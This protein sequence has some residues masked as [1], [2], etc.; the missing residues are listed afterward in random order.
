MS[1]SI[2]RTL[3]IHFLF[4]MNGFRENTYPTSLTVY[5]ARVFFICI[6]LTGVP[7]NLFGAYG[8]WSSALPPWLD[9][10]ETS[11][12]G[13]YR[14]NYT[15][16][17][18][19]SSP[20]AGHADADGDGL[21][22]N[23]ETARIG[24][25][26][27]TQNTDS[28]TDGYNN[29]TEFNDGSWPEED[30]F[31]PLD[32]ISPATNGSGENLIA[33]DVIDVLNFTE[34]RYA[35]W[36]FNPP[37]G[38]PLNVHIRYTPYGG[39]G[40]VNPLWCSPDIVEDLTDPDR[41]GVAIH[42]LF[43]NVQR[44]Y[45]DT[46]S[47][48]KWFIEGSARMSQ[49]FFY[50][51]MDQ[52]S[53]SN[54]AGQVSG[55][56]GAHNDIG[57]F[58]R[59]YSAVFFWKYL[60][61]QTGGAVTGQPF[62]GFDAMDQY[63][64]A[65]NGLEAIES[66]QSHLDDLAADSYWYRKDASH[67][68]ATWATALYTRQFT[69]TSLT[70]PYY[71]RDEQENL[72]SSLQRPIAIVNAAYSAATNSY[73]P[74]AIPLNGNVLYNDMNNSTWT[75]QVDT[76]RSN[77]YAFTPHTN[78]KIVLLWVDGK[79]GQNN[80][81]AAVTS[82][83][84]DVTDISFTYGEDH[85]KA[86]FNKDIDE[87]GVVVTSLNNRADYDLMVWTLSDFWLNITYPTN[88]DKEKVRLPLPDDLSTFEVHL[89]VWTEKSENPDDDI[90][91]DG[92]S[93]DLFEVLVD[94]QQAAVLSG[95]QLMDEYWLTCSAPDL[96]IGEYDLEV[97]LLDRSD[98][99]LK[100]LVYQ[101]LPHVDR[102]VVIDRSGSMGSEL[103]GNNEKML[104]AKSGGRLYTDLLVDGDMLGLVSFGGN[105]HDDPANATLHKSL[106]DVT[107]S[108]K[109]DVIDAIDNDITDDPSQYEHTAMGQGIILGYDWL[110]A[111]GKPDDEWR[112]AL[113]TD[114]IEDR[115]PYWADP[116]VSG[117]VVPSKVKIDAIA[118]GSGAHEHRLN[119][120]A[121]ETDGNYFHVSVPSNAAS[122]ALKAAGASGIDPVL[123]N[124][125]ANVFRMINERDL[126]H[127]RIWSAEGYAGSVAG[128]EAFPVY[129]G[130]TDLILTINWPIGSPITYKLYDPDG[131][132]H[133]PLYVSATHAV[134]H[135]PI[136]PGHWRIDLSADTTT[137]YL[138]VLSGRGSIKSKLIIKHPDKSVKIGSVQKVCLSLLSEK[139]DF[140]SSFTMAT[141]VSPT[142]I[143]KRLELF[144]DGNHGDWQSEDGI[145]CRDYR[146]TPDAG[147]YDVSIITEGTES[148]R[149]YRIEE[150]GFF[151]IATDYDRDKDEMPDEWENRYHLQ[152]SENDSGGDEDDDGVTNLQEFKNG[153]HPRN[154]DTDN[155]GTQDGSELTNGYDL[156]DF[157][158]DRIGPPP[159]LVINLQPSDAFDPDYQEPPSRSNLIYWSRGRSYATVDIYRSFFAGG[160]YT[161]I[162]IDYPATKRP[163]EDS[164]LVNGNKYYYK[165][166][167]KSRTG[168]MSRLSKEAMGI[169]KNDNLAPYGWFRIAGPG[170][171]TNPSVTL[172][173]RASTDTTSMRF[174][175]SQD[176][177]SSSWEPFQPVRNNWLISG[178]RG[179]NFVYVQFRDASDNISLP[180]SHGILY[181]VDKDGDGL[182][183]DWE[184]L[185][186]RNLSHDG[187]G[188]LPDKDGVKNTEE[189]QHGTSPMT[190]DTDRDGLL[191]S[192]EIKFTT[193]PT[194][195]DAQADPD[196]DGFSNEQEAAG[197]TDPQN[198]KDFPGTLPGDV[199]SSGLLDLSDLII[200]LQV[201][202]GDQPK[203]TTV[204]ADINDDYKVG[205]VESV[206]II[207]QLAK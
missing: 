137:P 73:S 13:N 148:K 86:Y 206:Y 100:S 29:L 2:F 17:L 98:S 136:I 41:R 141:I 183:D 71:Y 112:I 9:Q 49:D 19:H 3:K 198:P 75:Q 107:D 65:A 104:A 20:Y 169:P 26:T 125:L 122:S 191:D 32:T 24:N 176:F 35:A 53:T 174:S 95:H 202:V 194:I 42:E 170:Y 34:G 18:H 124:R 47:N 143:S 167:A 162:E 74:E 123:E 139:G 207:N 44:A 101:E 38:L 118:L 70:P 59:S 197:G 189:Y 153:G 152:S 105:A 45:P 171:T 146:R 12:S 129:E 40:N 166:A 96:P 77:Y 4:F 138:A 5:G 158:D 115:S 190:D 133:S 126:G 117:V 149:Q 181:Q 1:K 63:M 203:T 157:S 23:W 113:L 131:G 69:P 134:Y 66:V 102:M 51:D 27:A 57:L 31:R 163:Y 30:F 33:Q 156:T 144:D 97:H 161:L 168:L 201:V 142:G 11:S 151:V 200:S 68:F 58:E 135:L 81:Y 130:M 119:T 182:G 175:N 154:D 108:Y 64:R 116:S 89:K 199:N 127:T 145:F 120:I 184:M 93:P 195:N 99:E 186:F 164:G 76:W 22:D 196:K 192:W 16:D 205:M 55:F 36:G 15:D 25:T 193:K 56:L 79:S 110:A 7:G 72:P 155:G 177:S 82:T 185:H 140:E 159:S 94:G 21:P 204:R 61:E 109:A 85:I 6:F 50:N 178:F 39:W 43:H 54:Y 147:T 92:L 187:G 165:I 84:R 128:S 80:Y 78:A 67:F 180:F 48:T 179:A 90:Y 88:S 173:L 160:P 121:D 172:H 8:D 14:I 28:D 46:P 106:A 10:I 91:V 103:M 132:D 150:N 87:L 62:E 114:G 188:D 83:G 52:D 37:W 111:R 60:V